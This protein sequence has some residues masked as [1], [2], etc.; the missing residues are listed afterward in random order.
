MADQNAVK[1]DQIQERLWPAA[2][3]LN[4]LPDETA[5]SLASRHHRLSGNLHANRTAKQLFGHARGGYPHDLPAGLGHLSAT[6]D[7]NL[8]TAESIALRHTVLPFFLSFA[9][10]QTREDALAAMTSASL[11]PLKAR[12]GLPASQFGAMANLKA[13]AQCMLA[14]VQRYGVSYWHVSH[15][16]PGVWICSDHQLCL[17]YSVS[18]RAGLGRFDWQL[19][20]SS[21]L[22]KIQP[23][24]CASLDRLGQLSLASSG[25]YERGLAGPKNEDDVRGTIVR[26]LSARHLASETGRLKSTSAA[27]ALADAFG[28]LSF[29]PDVAG[30]NLQPSAL[31]ARLHSMIADPDRGHPLS[32]V[33]L[34]SYVFEGWPRFDVTTRS[35]LAVTSS[36]LPIQDGPVALSNRLASYITSGLSV[37]AAACEAGVSIAAAQAAL[38]R[39]G[40]VL[41]RRP[42]KLRGKTLERA[43]HALWRGLDVH[44]VAKFTNVAELTIRRLVSTTV[45]LKAH[46]EAILFSKQ[47]Q[48]A[49]DAYTAALLTARSIPHTS[50]RALAA[51]DHAWLYRNDRAWL[52]GTH[53]AVRTP[54]RRPSERVDWP[55][56][57]RTLAEH[58][59]AAIVRLGTGLPGPIALSKL[60]ELVPTLRTQLH[61]L[62]RLPLTAAMLVKH[63]RRRRGRVRATPSLL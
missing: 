47:R 61:H 21:D 49:R 7:G 29:C 13:C 48:G 28:T 15:Q 35:K 43:L 44:Q 27:S 33:V 50:A 54:Q 45:G 24:S 2:P 9:S 63:I 57:D 11:G 6:A 25:A 19:P 46:R 62:S 26:G 18:R 1:N 52:V 4:W 42:S 32:L 31:Y 51:K 59:R 16:I 40:H 37:R 20:T 60:V 56:R 23:R 38:A 12:L 41:A 36:Q 55:R 58:C 8:G 17:A 30:I 22:E 5:Y 10:T 14:D 39:A 53:Q 34:L 3:H